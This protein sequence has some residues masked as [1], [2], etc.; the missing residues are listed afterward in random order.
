MSNYRPISILPSISKILEKII[1]D[2]L[3][4]FVITWESICMVSEG[5]KSFN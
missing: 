1:Y 5:K 4:K 3:Y 2:R